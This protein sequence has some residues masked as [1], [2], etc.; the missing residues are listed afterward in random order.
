[1]FI[2]PPPSK[3]NRSGTSSVRPKRNR[4]VRP[5]QAL[6]PT[7]HRA[8]QPQ[9]AAA[10]PPWHPPAA[11]LRTPCSVISALGVSAP[12]PVPT[13]HP[14]RRRSIPHTPLARTMPFRELP[15]PSP[16]S[17]TA[18]F[19][20][21]QPSPLPLTPRRTSLICTTYATALTRGSRACRLTPC[22]CRQAL[23]RRPPV[24]HPRPKPVKMLEFH[25]HPLESMKKHETKN[26]LAKL[27]QGMPVSFKHAR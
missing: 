11:C 24:V 13:P 4:S 20:R 2:F 7:A 10:A 17:R 27:G 9:P 18:P 8:P 6:R 22:P 21:A 26:R 12:H 14:A 15:T 5:V 1:M 25:A 23:S 16:P 19:P 3:R